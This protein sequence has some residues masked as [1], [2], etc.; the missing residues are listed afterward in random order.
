MAKILLCVYGSMYLY[1]HFY[2]SFQ[3]ETLGA[4]GTPIAPEA[5]CW[6]TDDTFDPST[7]QI[8][9]SQIGGKER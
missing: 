5:D 8:R 1:T 9:V 7:A 2:L 4:V 6:N 3:Q